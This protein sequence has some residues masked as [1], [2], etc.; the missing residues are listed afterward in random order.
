[1]YRELLQPDLRIMIDENDVEGMREFCE[2]LHPAATAEVLEDID[3]KLAWRVLRTCSLD[4]QVE[5]LEFISL[6]KQVGLTE[7]ID[8][9][10]L[11]RLL[12]E[13]APDDRVDLLSRMDAEKVE[14]LLPSIAQAERS[15]IR[16]LLS[17]PESSAGALMTTEY[18][19]LPEN[20]TVSEALDRLRKQA[21]DRETVYYIYILDEGRHLHGFISL[22]DL[23]LAKPHRKLAD[24]MQHD[25]ISVRVTDDQEVVAQEMARYDFIAIP[26]V[27]NQNRLVGIVTHD[28]ILDVIH[29]EATEDVQ[30][31]AAMEPLEDGYLT[32]PIR[33][34]T[35]KRG[36]WLVL[37]LGAALGTAS[38][39]SGYQPIAEQEPWMILFLPM[40]LA[41]GGNAGSQS[42]TLVIRAV[43]LGELGRKT[44]FRI[45]WREVLLASQLGACLGVLAFLC[46]L[47]FN[48]P[49]RAM[50][51][52]ATVLLVVVMG[53]V[54]GSMLPLLFKRLGMDP[55][56]MSNPLIA[57][58]VDMM[59]VVIYFNVAILLLH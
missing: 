6:P 12:E 38:V 20:I 1:M 7:I 51:V 26:V 5:I 57:A 33:I 31:L 10:R 23:I 50:T 56:L 46:A 49:A 40:V 59:G 43:S 19:S 32:T 21:P 58:I 35:W 30:R 42:A 15:D 2:I 53:A 16:K 11:T 25:V 45:F 34:L 36:V 55:A 22:R 18:A 13:M 17:Y 47:I 3:S 39:V 28:D 9:G 14:N 29:E 54:T 41:S 52:A 4:R 48:P 27:D 8:R 37:L 44:A 24:I